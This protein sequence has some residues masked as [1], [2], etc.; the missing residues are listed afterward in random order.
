MRVAGSIFQEAESDG[1]EQEEHFGTAEQR[2]RGADSWGITT[3]CIA[4]AETTSVT[5]EEGW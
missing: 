4:E 1:G 3:E 2:G 5:L